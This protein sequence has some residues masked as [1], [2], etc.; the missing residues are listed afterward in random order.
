MS[1]GEIVDPLLK[2]GW[3]WFT[4]AQTTLSANWRESIDVKGKI[5]LPFKIFKSPVVLNETSGEAGKKIWMHPGF[6]WH[7]ISLHLHPDPQYK[8]AK[9]PH[10]TQV[11]LKSWLAQRET[12]DK[13]INIMPLAIVAFP[14]T[15]SPVSPYLSQRKYCWVCMCTIDKT[16][17][18][19]PFL[20]FA[21]W[22]EKLGTRTTLQRYTHVK[23][24]KAKR[25]NFGCSALVCLTPDLSTPTSETLPPSPRFS[26]LT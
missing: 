2:W 1:V 6:V 19:R 23:I 22:Y 21:L 25:G 16:N 3:H 26:A 17:R 11:H 12:I 5:T 10:F 24:P 13:Y 20:M 15:S 9:Q 8:R 14:K 18:C 7:S 4:R